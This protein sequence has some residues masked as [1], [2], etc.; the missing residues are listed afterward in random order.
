MSIALSSTPYLLGSGVNLFVG[1]ENLKVSTM[2]GQ[3][4][5]ALHEIDGGNKSLKKNK[6]QTFC[7][8][9]LQ[10]VSVFIH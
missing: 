8:A 6:E 3:P 5:I 2:I 9:V 10:K 4:H 1:P 7:E